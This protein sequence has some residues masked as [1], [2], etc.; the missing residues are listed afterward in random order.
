MRVLVR[1]KDTLS[2]L[3]SIATI[4]NPRAGFDRTCSK[5]HRGDLPGPTFV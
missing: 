2:A 4:L 5:S 3:C 1:F